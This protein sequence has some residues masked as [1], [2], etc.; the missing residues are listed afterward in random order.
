M[1]VEQRGEDGESRLGVQENE[2]L[3]VISVELCGEDEET[4]WAKCESL[5]ACCHELGEKAGG[6]WVVKASKLNI[7]HHAYIPVE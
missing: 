3:P 1:S 2:G 7:V 6:V 5:C 4:E